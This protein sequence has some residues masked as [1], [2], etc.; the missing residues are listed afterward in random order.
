[1][2]MEALCAGWKE[3]AQCV[4]GDPPDDGN[5]FAIYGQVWGAERL[6]PKAIKD[7]RAFWY[8]DNGFWKP[9]RGSHDGYY[10][11]C[12]RSMQPVLLGN[13]SAARARASGIRMAPWRKDGRHILFALPGLDYGEAMGLRMAEWIAVTHSMLRKRTSRPIYVRERGCKV[14]LASHLR[15]CWAMVT[16]SSN[17]A[18][19]AALAGIPVFVDAG[20]AAAPVGNTDLDRLEEPQMP[21]REHWLASLACQQF[22]PAEMANG[23][24]Y[25]LLARVR[26]V[27][28][29]KVAA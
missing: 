11:I 22:T 29:E 28:D 15:D 4:V 17:V 23:T 21:D 9:G 1:M 14:S 19:E 20:A 12:Y 8:I 26:D 18:V 7:A 25:S 5:P 16:H 13:V 6:L 3:P 2:V 27:V 24:A 10:R